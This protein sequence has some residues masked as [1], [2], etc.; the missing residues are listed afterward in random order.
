MPE[1]HVVFGAGPLGKWT[2]RALVNMGKSVRMVNRSGKASGLPASVEVVASDAY[3][4]HRNIELTRGAEVIYQCARPR[5]SEWVEKFPPL[6]TAILE[7]AAANSAKLIVGDNLYMYGR[8]SGILRED[9]PL[10]PNSTKGRLRAEM[11]QA[12]L[13]AHA[14]GKVRAA[15]G[16]ASDFFGPDDRG[17]T[18]YA[19][20]PA[21]QGRPVNLLGQ[22]DLP[23]TYTYVAD[24]G[25]LLAELG[26]REE[27]LGQVWFA[28]S[29]A[30]VTQAEFVDLLEAELGRSVRKRVA[31]AMIL[32]MAGLFNRDLAASVEMLFLWTNPYVVD[33]GKAERAFAWKATPLRESLRQTLAWCRAVVDGQL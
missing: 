9:S 25:R 12:V 32:R 10:A 26:T 14:S 8:P 27:A 13:E 33:T 2:A 5:Y 22:T 1:L 6:Q 28:P 20:L 24:F 17:L 4:L 29:N 3:D 21:T 7:A 15:I 16:R 30:P 18:R 11:A 23:H 31:G 19:I